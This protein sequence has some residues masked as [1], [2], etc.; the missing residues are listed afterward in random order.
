MR[1]MALQITVVSIV[2]STIC[3]SADQRKYQSSASLA[4]VTGN[5]PLTSEF[6]AQK[7]S[8]AEIFPF[9]DVIM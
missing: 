7:A 9:D 8:N 2:H 4:F 5:S 3:S 1:T 6:P